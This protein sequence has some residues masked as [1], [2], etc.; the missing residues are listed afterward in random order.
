MW[1]P[2]WHGGGMTVQIAIRLPDDVVAFLDTSVTVGN[3]PSRVALVACAVER[4]MRRQ[5]AEHDA[6]ILRER[7]TADE[8]DELG[9]W[10]VAHPTTED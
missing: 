10:S 3:A 9:S 6:A 8:L 5:V 1:D 7:G 4:D 2:R